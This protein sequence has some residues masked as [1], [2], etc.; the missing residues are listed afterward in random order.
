MWRK[1]T[2]CALNGR[3][4]ERILSDSVFSAKNKRKISIVHSQLSISTINGSA[5]HL[6]RKFETEKDG[7][8]ASQDMVNWYTG[9]NMETDISNE[10]RDI[11]EGLKFHSNITSSHYINKFLTA[12]QDLNRIPNE[13]YTETHV[14]SL[15]LDNIIDYDFSH[16]TEYLKNS[17]TTTLEEF[18]S[19]IRKT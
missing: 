15:F 11:L 10:K 19:D 3:G 9:E 6:V 18:V 5:H 17:K 14:M 1:R 16:I 2:E 7:Y 4:Y 12:H 13:G 8:S